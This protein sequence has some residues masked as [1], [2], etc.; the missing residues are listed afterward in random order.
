MIPYLTTILTSST[1]KSCKKLP[2][3][4]GK[5]AIHVS[6]SANGAFSIVKQPQRGAAANLTISGSYNSSAELT[7]GTVS[8]PWGSD[9]TLAASRENVVMTR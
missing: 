9:A 1:H 8:R 3:E 5:G 2:R 7:V 4:R 6:H